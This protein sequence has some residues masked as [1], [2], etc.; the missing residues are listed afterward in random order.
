MSTAQSRAL[1]AL[2]HAPVYLYRWHLGWLLRRRFLLL[3]HTGHRTGQKREVVLEVMEYRKQVPEA[4]VM[5]GFGRK[6]SWLL[7]LQ[8]HPG[9]EVQIGSQRWVASFR[10]L[11][12]EEATAV[13]RSYETRNWLILPVVRYVLSRLLGWRYSGSE[14]ERRRLVSQLPLIAFRPKI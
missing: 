13:V 5:S 10:F 11:D 7:N 3:R 2:L 12:A 6:S 1:K 14:Q 9:A 4:V 8:A